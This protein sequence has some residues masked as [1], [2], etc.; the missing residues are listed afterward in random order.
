MRA[1]FAV[2]RQQLL[3][4]LQYRAGFWGTTVTHVVWVYVRV[5]I[6]AIFY[7]YGSGQAAGQIFFHHVLCLFYSFINPH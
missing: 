3:A 7:R 6:V 1:Y 2:F 5:V 4:G